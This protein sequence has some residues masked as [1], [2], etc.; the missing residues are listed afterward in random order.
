MNSLLP[1]SDST[2]YNGIILPTAAACHLKS[3]VGHPV[4]APPRGRF[5]F[6]FGFCLQVFCSKFFVDLMIG[7]F[8]QAEE[9]VIQA[10]AGHH[11]IL[12]LTRSAQEVQAQRLSTNIE[13]RFSTMIND[14]RLSSSERIPTATKFMYLSLCCKN[15]NITTFVGLENVIELLVVSYCRSTYFACHAFDRQ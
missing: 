4:P 12:D 2:K 6:T 8:W 5:C 13:L 9:Q 14:G 10:T 11:N 15:N 3:G 1:W 7:F